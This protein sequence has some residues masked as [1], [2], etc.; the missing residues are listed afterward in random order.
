MENPFAPQPEPAPPPACPFADVNPYGANFFLEW[1]PEEWKVDKT[2]QMAHE[3]GI[4]WVK[5]QFSWDSLQL[6]P[7]ENGYWD[8]HLNQ[9]TWDKYD[10]IVALANKYNLQVIARLDRPPNWTRADNT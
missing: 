3:A 7:G 8:E 6:T 2:L 1:E 5:Q 9:S 10:R 4:G